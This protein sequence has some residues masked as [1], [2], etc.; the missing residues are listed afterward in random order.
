MAGLSQQQALHQELQQYQILQLNVLS[1]TAEELR[2]YLDDAQEENPLIELTRDCGQYE[3]ELAVGRWLGSAAPERPEYSAADD[4]LTVPDIPCAD[5]ETL[6]AHLRMQICFSKLSSELR[7]AVSFLIGSL[8]E[9][10]RLPLSAQQIAAASRCSLDCAQQAITLVQSL[11]PAGV[12]AHDLAECLL[13]QLQALPVRSEAA[14][15]IVRTCLSAITSTS[16]AGIAAK[17]GLRPE[18]V[19]HAIAL[20]RTLDPRPGAA[21]NSSAAP[22]IVPDIIARPDGAG[23]WE[24]QL[25]DRWIG[26]IGIS[27]YYTKLLRTADDPDASAYLA[28][29]LQHAKQLMAAIERR[30][31]TMLEIARTILSVQAGFFR[32]HAPLVPLQLDQIAEQVGCHRSTISRAIRGKYLSWPGGCVALRQMLVQSAACSGQTQD[33]VLAEIRR[34]ILQED[35]LHPLSD[36]AISEALAACGTQIAR[37]TVVKYREMLG[38]P[39]AHVR[40]HT[41]PP[42]AGERSSAL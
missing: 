4:D 3:Q 19:K 22:C 39:G 8:D 37:R 21:Y 25:N 29:R 18:Q 2:S 27:Q 26:T 24:L 35:P 17:C 1:M 14:E 34:L 10:G 40:R 38:L 20:I 42:P 13:L 36:Q 31:A 12:A 15:A 23:G 16:A 7:A 41:A 28:N 9:N 11:D 30:R 5:E 32:D 6:E 33:R